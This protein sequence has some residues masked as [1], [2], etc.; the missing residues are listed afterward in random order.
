MSLER[1]AKEQLN[2]TVAAD[3][4][5][6]WIWECPS[7][8]SVWLFFKSTEECVF[9]SL[10]H[11]VLLHK[12]TISNSHLFSLQTLMYFGFDECPRGSPQWVV[13]VRKLVF[14]IVVHKSHRFRLRVATTQCSGSCFQIQNEF[15][16]SGWAH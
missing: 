8:S 14:A 12:P 4:I 1:N 3:G 6:R 9:P 13:K 10:L 15:L 16:A 7:K 5:R 11:Q 2:P